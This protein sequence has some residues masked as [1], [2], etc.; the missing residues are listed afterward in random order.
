MTEKQPKGQPEQEE[1]RW[2]SKRRVG[3]GFSGP[4]A[5]ETEPA[6]RD[7]LHGRRLMVDAESPAP[8]KESGDA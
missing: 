4:A 8:G 6:A 1:A 2:V 3:R 5:E 7:A